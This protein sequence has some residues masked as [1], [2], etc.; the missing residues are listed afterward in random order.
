MVVME[1]MIDVAASEFDVHL[2]LS[3]YARDDQVHIAV[4]IL[5]R[6]RQGWHRGRRV[7]F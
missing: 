6:S 3:L 1:R 7:A 2:S 5:T 4:T